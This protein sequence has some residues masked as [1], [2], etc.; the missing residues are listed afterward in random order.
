[1]K[2]ERHALSQWAE[3]LMNAISI[4]KS[5]SGGTQGQ[6]SITHIS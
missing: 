1:M 4:C 6:L 3:L 2:Y 5:K